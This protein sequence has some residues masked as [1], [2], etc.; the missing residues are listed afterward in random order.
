MR[1]GGSTYTIVVS[2]DSIRKYNGV[3]VTGINVNSTHIK[4]MSISNIVA[5][6]CII[7]Y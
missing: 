3:N 6:E 1:N 5:P 7:S 4:L 2:P